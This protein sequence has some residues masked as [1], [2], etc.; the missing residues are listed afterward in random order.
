MRSKCAQIIASVIN[1][2][3]HMCMREWVENTTKVDLLVRV[4]RH[5][6]V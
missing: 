6:R 1:E 3:T 4:V 2:Y 5:A